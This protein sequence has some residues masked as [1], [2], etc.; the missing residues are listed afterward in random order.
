MDNVQA[1]VQFGVT[2][3]FLFCVPAHWSVYVVWSVWLLLWNVM[4]HLGYELCPAG[5]VTHPVAGLLTTATHHALH[6]SDPR[7]HYGL[8]F[9]VLDRLCGSEDPRYAAT[10]AAQHVPPAL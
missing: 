3:V 2:F 5:F 8:Y 6:H 10:F 1:V 4:G 9:T 7:H